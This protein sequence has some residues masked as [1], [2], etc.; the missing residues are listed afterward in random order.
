M[1]LGNATP[2]EETQSGDVFPCVEIVALTSQ[3][4]EFRKLIE[5]GDTEKTG[6]GWR[7]KGGRDS[8]LNA[9]VGGVK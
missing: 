2:N 9:G 7:H 5:F 6:G 1:K 8:D 4:V 3:R